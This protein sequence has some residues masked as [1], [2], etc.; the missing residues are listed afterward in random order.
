MPFHGPY[1]IAEVLERDNYRL[2]DLLN[3]RLINVVHVDRLVPYPSVTNH[4]DGSLADDEY[5]VQRIIGRRSHPDGEGFQYKVRWRGLEP[6]EDSWLSLEELAYCHDLVREYNLHVDPLPDPPPAPERERL[7]HETELPPQPSA[8]GPT[9]RSRPIRDAAPAVQ[10]DRAQPSQ[11]LQAREDRDRLRSQ[12]DAA[13]EPAIDP[14]TA[15]FQLAGIVEVRKK[16]RGHEALVCFHN[17]WV[18]IN[19]LDDKRQREVLDRLRER[20]IQSAGP[21]YPQARKTYS[22]VAEIIE[23]RAGPH[24]PE[25]YVRWS[26]EWTTLSNLTQAARAEALAL[27]TPPSSVQGVNEV[28]QDAGAGDTAVAAT[29]RLT[30]NGAAVVIQRAFRHYLATRH[31]TWHS[32]ASFNRLDD[33]RALRRVRDEYLFRFGDG[34]SQL[35]LADAALT[36]AQRRRCKALVKALA[37]PWLEPTQMH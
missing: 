36:A 29:E 20:G 33:P 13:L 5:F 35:W 16:G 2:R 14:D 3:R 32:P 21:P 1:R 37:L 28:T 27:L 8:Q 26:P 4:G 30:A 24:M 15:S 34:I 31:Q 17:T 7:I 23:V 22:D 12:A 11:P 19:I 10:T 25:A 18:T 9:F 6:K